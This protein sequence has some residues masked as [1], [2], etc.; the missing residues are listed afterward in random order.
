[1]DDYS[2]SPNAMML[3][4]EARMAIE[5]LERRIERLESKGEDPRA[6]ARS[7]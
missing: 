7:C 2:I 4:P 3:E 6:I 5:T 1:M